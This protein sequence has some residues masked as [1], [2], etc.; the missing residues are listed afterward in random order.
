MID[1]PKFSSSHSRRQRHSITEKIAIVKESFQPNVSIAAVA[2]EHRI[3]ANL[4]HKWRW[5]YRNGKFDRYGNIT[6]LIPVQL[7]AQTLP[8]PLSD[9]PALSTAEP[10]YVEIL[11]GESRVWVHGNV[12]SKALREI[13]AALG[14]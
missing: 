14:S 8:E 7:S 12:Q 1:L 4:L 9:V 5:E 13:F 3:N 2:L 6:S 11:I 10:G